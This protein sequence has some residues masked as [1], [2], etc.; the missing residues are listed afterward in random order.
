[1]NVSTI[2]TS[3]CHGNDHIREHELCSDIYT[4]AGWDISVR[5]SY[6]TSEG[7]VAFYQVGL[8]NDA[9]LVTR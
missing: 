2:Y 7:L 5:L 9:S 1:M 8:V 3:S 6:P 4:V